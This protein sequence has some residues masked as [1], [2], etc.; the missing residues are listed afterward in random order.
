MAS[1]RR[2]MFYQNNKQETTEIGQR[3]GLQTEKVKISPGQRQASLSTSVRSTCPCEIRSVIKFFTLGRKSENHSPL[4]DLR[5]K[6]VEDQ[7][8]HT[9]YTLAWGK[10]DSDRTINMVGL[11]RAVSVGKI[12]DQQML[13]VCA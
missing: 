10:E 7:G 1:K 6:V 2:N 11:K 12:S 9:E 3:G 5:R 8:A 13:G 4:V